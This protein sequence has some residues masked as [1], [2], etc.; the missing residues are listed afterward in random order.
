MMIQNPIPKTIAAMIFVL[1]L[2]PAAFA[3]TCS[4]LCGDCY[5]TGGAGIRCNSMH[6]IS[7]EGNSE[8]EAYS[9]MTAQCPGKLENNPGVRDYFYITPPPAPQLIDSIDLD[10]NP[11]FVCQ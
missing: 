3:T 11:N 6:A 10:R 1:T 2:A 5:D 4:A 9:K 8:K 7:G